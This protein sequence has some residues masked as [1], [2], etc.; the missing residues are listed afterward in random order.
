MGEKYKQVK[1]YRCQNPR[2]HIDTSI[3]KNLND[4]HTAE[5]N[6]SAIPSQLSSQAISISHPIS[7]KNWKNNQY[8]Q[9]KGQP[10]E[11]KGSHS[12]TNRVNPSTQDVNKSHYRQKRNKSKIKGKDIKDI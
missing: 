4:T 8:F 5:F 11:Y 9:E 3:Q 2:S 10:K 1:D 7:Y 12:F 6:M